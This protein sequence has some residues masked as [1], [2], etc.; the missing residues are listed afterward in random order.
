METFKSKTLSSCLSVEEKW[1]REI[2]K[3]SQR[4]RFPEEFSI[5]E[6]GK[7]VKGHSYIH[8]LCPLMEDG[9]LR[10]GGRLSRSSVPAEA[11]YP[12]ILAKDLHISILLLRHVHQELGHS[13][14]NH[15][16]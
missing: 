1:E 16:I 8:T 10:V 2:I 14:R 4:K 7:S 3:Y 9:V 15:V 13:G 12:V 11:K 6:K 5:L